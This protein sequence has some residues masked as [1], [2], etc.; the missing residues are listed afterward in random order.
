MGLLRLLQLQQ[1]SSKKK[2]IFSG[3]GED[4]LDSWGISSFERVQEI[5]CSNKCGKTLKSG[6]RHICKHPSCNKFA[7]CSECFDD[8]IESERQQCHGGPWL[9]PH[10]PV[11]LNVV[12]AQKKKKQRQKLDLST[13][14]IPS[15]VHRNSTYQQ[16]QSQQ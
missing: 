9:P 8:M 1:T 10:R 15:Y 12:N 5:G 7:L 4:L 2:A 11:A 6:R 3:K 13:Q 14:H 16:Q